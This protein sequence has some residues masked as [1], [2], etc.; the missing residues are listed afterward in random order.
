MPDR[1][2]PIC[3]QEIVED[4]DLRS[5]VNRRQGNPMS[6]RSLAEWTAEHIREVREEQKYRYPDDSD[7]CCRGEGIDDPRAGFCARGRGCG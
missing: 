2:F 1:D 4:T 6:F 5:R 7:R 3:R